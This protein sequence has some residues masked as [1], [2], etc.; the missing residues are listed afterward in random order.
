MNTPGEHSP[1]NDAPSALEGIK[2]HDREI[3]ESSL[4]RTGLITL[5]QDVHSES[6]R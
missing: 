5:T 1:S 3:G 4:S 6:Y 2:A